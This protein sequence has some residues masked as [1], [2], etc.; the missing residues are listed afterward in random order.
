V[1]A[2]NHSPPQYQ[3]EPAPRGSKTVPVFLLNGT[4]TSAGPGPGVKHLHP[5]EAGA[6]VSAH[7]AVAGDQ[8][9]RGWSGS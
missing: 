3:P 4:R 1:T 6:L 9:P 7:L 2:T 8:P 5:A